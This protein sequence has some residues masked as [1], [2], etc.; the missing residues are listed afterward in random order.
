M[1]ERGFTL[2]ELLVALVA[3]SFILLALGWSV[4]TLARELRAKPDASASVY[5]AA[6]IL[7]RLIERMQPVAKGDAPILMEEDSFSL[8][9]SP[10]ESFGSV[11][12]VR[13]HLKVDDAD[14]TRLLISFEPTMGLALPAA[15]RIERPIIEGYREISFSYKPA[16]DGAPALPPKLVT[17]HLTALDGKESRLS[18]ATKLNAAA[19]CRFDPISMTCRP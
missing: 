2:I 13:M 19:D 10:P 5:A 6:P 14:T 12:P 3:G 15:A 16:E 11:G 7:R 4:T 8:T 1:N 17:I 18:I 9:T